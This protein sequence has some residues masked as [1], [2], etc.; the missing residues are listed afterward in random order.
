MG[1]FNGL[2]PQF[3]DLNKWIL[4]F[5]KPEIKD[6]AF[7]YPYAN[8]GFFIL[9][10]NLEKEMSLILTQAHGYGENIYYV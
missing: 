8:L 4:E 2:W 6:D 9:E 10:F 1:S 3:M 7:I 5:S